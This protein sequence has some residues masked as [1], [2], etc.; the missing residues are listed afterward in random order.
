RGGVAA[1][2]LE[3]VPGF[4]E[5]GVAVG[6]L[7]GGATD[8]EWVGFA[9]M[10]IMCL[11]LVFTGPIGVAV[12]GA[13]DFAFAGMGAGLAYVRERAQELGGVGSSFRAEGDAFATSDGYHDSLLAG[14]AALLSAI[15]FFRAAKELR[16]LATA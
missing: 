7:L 11:G 10:A 2:H 4:K 12:L 14:A 15:A 3:D 5:Y 1:L 9:A 8:E 6:N 13:A 16:Q